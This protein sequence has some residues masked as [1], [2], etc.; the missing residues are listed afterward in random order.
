MLV[1][2]N[3]QYYLFYVVTSGQDKIAAG[4][5]K[6]LL[7]LPGHLLF[8]ESNKMCLAS[9][10]CAWCPGIFAVD[11]GVVC[12]GAPAGWVW[13][14]SPEGAVGGWQ[15]AATTRH[16]GQVLWPRQP[17][18]L[19]KWQCR[20]VEDPTELLFRVCLGDLMTLKVS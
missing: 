4:L 12:L 2:I 1:P 13:N 17:E 18:P 19:P 7:T 3:L 9:A 6:L 11:V 20:A 16:T 8:I 5:D 10:L 14:C 15:R